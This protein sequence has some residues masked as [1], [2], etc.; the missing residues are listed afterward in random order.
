[1]N[2]YRRVKNIPLIQEVIAPEITISRIIGVCPHCKAP[3]LVFT[4]A[5]DEYVWISC[6]EGVLFKSLKHSA[7]QWCQDCEQ[8]LPVIAGHCAEC[9]QRVMLAPD[10]PCSMCGGSRFWRHLANKRKP[11]GFAW[12]CANCEEPT[13]KVAVYEL[14][15]EQQEGVEGL[16]RHQS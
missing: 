13:G 14:T 16:C 15:I 3:L 8:K 2:P 4:H 7:P 6:P 1:M 5:L 11:A 10:D 12:R 9:I